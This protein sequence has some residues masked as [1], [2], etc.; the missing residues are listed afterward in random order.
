MP[1]NFEPKRLKPKLDIVEK[2]TDSN[3]SH[4]R[5]AEGEISG[6]GHDVLEMASQVQLS[7]HTMEQFRQKNSIDHSVFRK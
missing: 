1:T 4:A 5:R 3:V 2:S 6:E 7:S